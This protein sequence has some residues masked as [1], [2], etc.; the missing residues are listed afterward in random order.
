MR[1]NTL[2][3]YLCAAMISDSVSVEKETRTFSI[4]TRTFSRKGN[5]TVSEYSVSTC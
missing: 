4:E 2:K 1:A 3:Y 5:R